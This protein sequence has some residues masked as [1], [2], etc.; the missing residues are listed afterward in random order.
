MQKQDYI[1]ANSTLQTKSIQNTLKLLEDGSTV[2]F[3]ARYR[4]EMTGGLDE[5][6]IGYVRNLAKKYDE[7]LSRQK[8]ILSSIEEQGKLSNELKTKIEN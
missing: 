6:E 7:I 8:T 1:Q 3:I 4:K 2:P 5:V